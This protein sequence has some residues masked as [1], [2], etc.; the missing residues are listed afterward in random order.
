MFSE[1]KTIG[2]VITDVI[3]SIINASI[4]LVPKIA[5][6]IAVYII[7]GLIINKVMGLVKSALSLRNYDASL[8]SFLQ[9]LVKS[10]L[11]IFLL[12]SIFGILGINLTSFAAILAGLAVGVGS[13]LNGTLG[14]FA[15][16]VM[17]LLFKPFKI[18][19]LI[20]T[21]GYTGSVIEQNIFNTI[22]LTE[23]GKTV[24]L[25]NGPVST[26]TIVN[27]SIFGLN[28]TTVKITIKGSQDL[29]Q[30]SEIILKQLQ[31]EKSILSNPTPS[32]SYNKFNENGL[33]IGIHFHT[34]NEHTD[35]VKSY[36][37]GQLS[38]LLQTNE[39]EILP[40]K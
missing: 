35:T 11:I 16:G 18:G 31:G 12:L 36:V 38:R 2:A 29:D 1:V 15:G 37:I 7:G 9:S 28:K 23:E 10:L 27:H 22:L 25:A 20:D 30:L 4:G 13:A 3:N 8:Q 24:I 5:G 34:Q 21:Q 26:G 6:A 17:M 39:I 32:I 14:N 40:N 33:E 19:D